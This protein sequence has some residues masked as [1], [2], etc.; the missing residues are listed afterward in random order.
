[1]YDGRTYLYGR[2]THT[3]TEILYHIHSE[4]AIGI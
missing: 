3:L 2:R 1:L 4:N